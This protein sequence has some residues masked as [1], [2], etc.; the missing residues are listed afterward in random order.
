VVDRPARIDPVPLTDDAI[1]VA[2]TPVV[3]YR[4]GWRPR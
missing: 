3:V 4:D 2:A 1:P